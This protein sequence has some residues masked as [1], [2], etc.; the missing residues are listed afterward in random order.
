[1]GSSLE[2]TIADE[3]KEMIEVI[4]R[5]NGSRGKISSWRDF[6]IASHPTV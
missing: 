3:I 4:T 5:I 2:C 6:V 1:V